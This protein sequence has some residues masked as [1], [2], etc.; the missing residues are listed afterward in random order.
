M[1]KSGSPPD[2][3]LKKRKNITPEN[4][5]PTKSHRKFSPD[6][7]EKNGVVETTKDHND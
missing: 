1:G 2:S 7:V 3:N 5:N 4:Q 6:K